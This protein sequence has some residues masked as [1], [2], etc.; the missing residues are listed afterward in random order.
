MHGKIRWSFHF[1]F[2]LSISLSIV[3][4]A[5]FVDVHQCKQ[6]TTKKKS[7]AFSGVYCDVPGR[8]LKSFRILSFATSICRNRIYTIFDHDEFTSTNP[9]NEEKERQ[10]NNC[11]AQCLRFMYD[12]SLYGPRSSTSNDFYLVKHIGYGRYQWAFQIFTI[13]ANFVTVSR[14]PKDMVERHLKNR[15]QMFYRRK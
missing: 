7:N 6:P 11:A 15:R 2:P 1:C 5:I 12:L 14:M 9:T 4:S 13:F 10:I 3:D 8:L